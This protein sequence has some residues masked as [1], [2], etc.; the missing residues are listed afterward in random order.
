MIRMTSIVC[1]LLAAAPALAQLPDG[2]AS[3]LGENVPAFKVRPGYRVTRALPDKSLKQDARF[4]QFSSDNK[5]LFLSQREVGTILALRDPD[6]S[7]VFKTVTTFVKDKRSA[8]GMDFRDG[9]L[10]FGQSSEG[11]VSRARD[12]NDDG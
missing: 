10:Y 12:T 11:S 7:G 2:I 9:W 1:A 6:E 8:H 3:D 5:T 4:L